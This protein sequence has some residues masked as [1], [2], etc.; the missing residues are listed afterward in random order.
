M[1]HIQLHCMAPSPPLLPPRHPRLTVRGKPV[2]LAMLSMTGLWP[3]G[4]GLAT[5]DQRHASV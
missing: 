3:G 5:E 1:E 4:S 2:M